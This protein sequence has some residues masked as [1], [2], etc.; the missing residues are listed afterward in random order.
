VVDKGEQGRE[1]DGLGVWGWKM[2]TITFRMD[3][4][5]L[6][7]STGNCIQY[8]VIYHSGKEY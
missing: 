8:P 2:Q 7:Y 6:M 5:T 3:K 4:Q 1:T